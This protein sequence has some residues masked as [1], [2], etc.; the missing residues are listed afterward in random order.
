MSYSAMQIT[1]CGNQPRHGKP[2]KKFAKKCQHR[3]IRRKMKDLNFVPQ[4][5]RFEAGWVD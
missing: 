5:N 2:K 4:Y 1:E 3:R